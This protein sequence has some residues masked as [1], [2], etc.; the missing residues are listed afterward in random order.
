MGGSMH[1]RRHILSGAAL[2]VLITGSVQACPNHTSHATRTAVAV[3]SQVRLA[4]AAIVA[5]KP[6]AWAPVGAVAATNQGLR[7][8][9]DPVDGAMGMPAPDALTQQVT[10]END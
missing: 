2:T 8:A 4:P 3:T 6:R 9:I 1:L 10:I 5:W 7:V